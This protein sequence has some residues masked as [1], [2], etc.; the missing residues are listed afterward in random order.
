MKF[1]KYTHVSKFPFDFNAPM[2]FP[3]SLPSGPN[4][5]QPSE[6]RDNYILQ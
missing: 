4:F 2:T 6:C 1:I 3:I 5:V